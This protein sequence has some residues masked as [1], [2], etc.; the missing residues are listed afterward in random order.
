M[1]WITLVRAATLV[2]SNVVRVEDS[3]RDP[4]GIRVSVLGVPVYDDAWEGVIRRHTRRAAHQEARHH[5]QS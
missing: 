5:G 1:P 3:Q 2:A 4:H